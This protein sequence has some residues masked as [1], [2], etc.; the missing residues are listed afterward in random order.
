MKNLL[1]IG[2]LTDQGH[3]A[4]FNNTCCA[5]YDKGN[6]NRIIL[7][8]TRDLSNNLYPLDPV[9][10]LTM[11]LPMHLLR[12]ST[13]WGLNIDEAPPTF[14][15]AATSHQAEIWHKRLGHTNYQRL[16]HMTSKNLVVG[17]PPI[18]HVRLDCE[19]CLK[20]KQ[21]R[22]NVPKL[23]HSVVTR[24]FELVHTDICGPL[25]TE[26]LTKSRYILMFT[27]HY[28]RFTW[29]YCLRNKGDSFEKFQ[30]FY[31]K[32]ENQYNYKIGALLSDRGGEFPSTAFDLF[33][34]EKGIARQLTSAYTPHQNGIA[35]QKNTTI[36]EMS[37][38]KLIDAHLPQ[39]LWEEAVLTSIYI[40]LTGLLLRQFQSLRFRC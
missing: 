40:L 15:L 6:P 19:V 11:S 13:I 33:L 34:S 16:H 38:A 1:S 26:S 3:I 2:K 8:G 36:L 35:E 28:T 14:Q 21:R 25:P 17:M 32:V 5:V 7:T 24:P 31:A 23:S 10:N 29:V 20:A 39:R 12:S 9:Q 18:H 22:E 37:L 4:V 30:D 27:D